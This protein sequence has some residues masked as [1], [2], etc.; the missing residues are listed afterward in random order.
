MAESDSTDFDLLWYLE[1]LSDKEF[2]NFKDHLERE[3]PQFELPQIPFL[4]LRKAKREDVVNIL[5]TSYEEQHIWN[6]IFSIFQKIH[7]KDLCEKIDA[8]RNRSKEMHRVLIRRNFLIQ[9]EECPFGDVHGEF[10]RKVSAD[11][12]YVLQ[13]AYNPKITHSSK[14]LN[15]LLVGDEA[16]GKTVAIK[17]AVLEWAKGN[18][19]KDVI[20]YIVC[21]T[22]HEINRMTRSSLIELISKDWPDGKAPIADILSSSQKLLFI[23]ED[24]DNINLKLNMN[25]SALCSDS[26]EQVPI[27]VLL[28]SLLKRKMAQDSWFLISSR[29]NCEAVVNTLM[30]MT[31]YYIT[32]ELSNEKRQE[33]FTIFFKDSQRAMTALKFVHENEMLVDLC[34]VPALCWVTCTVL[35][36]QMDKRDD[37][38]LSCQTRTD[39]YAHFLANTLTS[40]AGVTANQHHLVLLE[41]LCLLAIEGLFHNTLNFSDEDLRSVGFTKVDVSLLQALNIL[42]PSSSRKDHHKFIHSNIQEFCAAIAYMMILINCQIPSASKKDKDKREIYINF[43]PIVTF[44]FGLLNEKRRKILE[45]SFGCQLLIGPLRQYFL[46]QMENLGNNP[47]AMEHHMPLFYCLFENQE[48]EFVKEIMGFFSEATICVEEDKDLMVSS[49]CLKQCQPLQK[50]KLSV[51]HIFENKRPNVQLTSSQMRN[52]VYWRDICSLL[53]T[54][55][56]LREL[57]ICNSDLDDTSER[58]LCKSLKHP[59]CQLQTLKLSYLSPLSEFEDI[60]KAI[61]HS[62]N[63]TFLSLSS[64]FITVKMFSLLH[65][66]LNN[67]MSSVRH[68][69]LIKCNLQASTCE[70]ISSLLI[71]SKKLKKLTLSNNPL[72][73]DG[74]KIL[75]DAL[76]Q[77]DCTLESLAL[78]FCCLTQSCCSSIGKVLMV[79]K[80]L[81]HLDLSVNYLRNHG[82]LVLTLAVMFPNCKLQELELSGCFFSS[83]VCGDIASAIINNPNLRSLELGS[84]NIQDEGMELLCNALKHK[85][86]KLENIGLE[87]CGL[88]S[89]C[90]KSLTSVLISSKTLKKLNL[91]K[92]KLGDK[93]IMQLLKG[94]RHPRCVLQTLGLQI[95][96]VGT[97]TQKLLMAVKEKNTK[98]VFVSESWAKR[99]GREVMVDLPNPSQPD[100]L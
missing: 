6:I 33:Y 87:E 92:N 18:M 1:N 99:K 52:L 23:F 83:D 27:S 46:Q 98:L 14:N 91:L 61:V 57:E 47:K 42:L 13:L 17:M 24:W 44:I 36:Q 77:P 50:L 86:C 85:N 45:A 95:S 19:W 20:S 67:P 79:K 34:R 88:T 60:F 29:P 56:N 75:C 66:V 69:N 11:I 54:H 74:V 80:S 70:K 35:N 15:V 10:Y 55:E 16:A 84:N 26:R 22:S 8:R 53:H 40:D 81:K 32:I 65:E 37:V 49:Y 51:Q 21:L 96:D 93:G 78:C 76:L 25:E 43:S 3:P 7:R 62:Q 5:T 41:R 2:Q 28:V 58:I 31:D 48:E 68:L 12:F 73:S 89:A 71:S 94:L 30:Q 9:W 97:E 38:K 64:T 63:L 72:K 4:K 100:P 82:V 90:C 59:S 39:I